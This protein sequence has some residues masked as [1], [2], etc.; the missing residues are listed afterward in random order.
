MAINDRN[1]SD[2][3]DNAQVVIRDAVAN[4][5]GAKVDSDNRLWVQ[6]NISQVPSGMMAMNSKLRYLDMNVSNGGIARGST[7]STSWVNVFNRSGSGYLFFA[8]V[9]FETNTDWEF[10]IVID[11]EELFG[12]SGISI[13]DII[14]NSIYDLDTVGKGN[15]DL[16]DHIGIVLGD[17]NRL[18]WH[19]PSGASLYF[20]SSIVI[21]IKRKAGTASKK[22]NA[23]LVSLTDG[24]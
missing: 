10:R 17:H 21:K 14:G 8:I 4:S 1:N 3:F 20:S 15:G 9:S 19:P 18:T 7:V 6:S 12:S 23:G 22:F 5:Y 2:V 13:N 24:F 16:D 11:G